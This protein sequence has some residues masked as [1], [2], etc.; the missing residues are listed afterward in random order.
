MTRKYNFEN[1]AN[2][3]LT[4]HQCDKEIRRLP[5]KM[6]TVN[7]AEDWVYFHNSCLKK[8]KNEQSKN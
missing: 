3:G 7:D 5:C 6:I 2:F 8:F 4:C 1:E